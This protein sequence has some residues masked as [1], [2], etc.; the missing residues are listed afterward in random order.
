M[1]QKS[2][3]FT[4]TCYND[5]PVFDD[6][7]KFM[8]Y[9]IETCPTTGRTH[10]QGFFGFK[11]ARSVKKIIQLYNPWHIEVM[12]GTINQNIKYCSKEGDYYEFG[13]MPE[14]GKRT[15]IIKLKTLTRM[16]D[17]VEVATNNMQV[18]MMEN[19]LKY[20][21][22]KRT[23][24][25]IVK[26]FYGSTGSGKTRTALEEASCIEAGH[27]EDKNKEEGIGN[28]WVSLRDGK[29]FEG[30]DGHPCVIFDDIRG[31]FM[32]FHEWLRILDRYEYRVEVKGGS[33]QFLAKYI[34][35]T[36]CYSPAQMWKNR[37]DEDLAQLTRRIDE[38]R[39]IG[40][41]VRGNTIDE[42]PF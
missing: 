20:K 15:D 9:G 7:M 18:R 11:N 17:V 31:D 27:L 12:K 1:A 22:K 24:K 39:L 32:K 37:S 21:E 10:Y 36:S 40:T 26:W 16:T 41:E 33:R 42:L 2:R 13:D 14:Q 5:E 19:Y 35:I 25:P 34:W 29:W 28:I 3:N 38:I 8:A 30:Y 6:A 23:W 4:F